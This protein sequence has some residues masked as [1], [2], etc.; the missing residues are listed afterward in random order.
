M[1]CIHANYLTFA[2]CDTPLDALLADRDLGQ[3]FRSTQVPESAQHG[4]EIGHFGGI[5]GNP[6]Q[7]DRPRLVKDEDG[8]L[9]HSR[10]PLPSLVLHSVLRADVS[11]PIR[12]ERKVHAQALCKRHLRVGGRH[13]DSHEAGAQVGRFFHSE[14]Q[15]GQF[16]RSNVAE[17]EDV[18]GQYDRA[19]SKVIRE[20]DLLLEGLAQSEARCQVADEGPKDIREI[21]QTPRCS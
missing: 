7:T 20:R 6:S 12:Q 13:R 9:G 11:V 1:H 21:H 14:S 17:V 15:L 8:P 2:A 4:V 3:R 18:E 16:R 10:V 5:V 19:L